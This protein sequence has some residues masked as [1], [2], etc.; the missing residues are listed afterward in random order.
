[1][2]S[3]PDSLFILSGDA[4]FNCLTFFGF[5]LIQTQTLSVFLNSDS[6]FLF[7]LYKPTRLSFLILAPSLNNSRGLYKNMASMIGKNVSALR[8][9]PP[10]NPPSTSSQANNSLALAA[11]QLP[12]YNIEIS[13]ATSLLYLLEI[14]DL[15]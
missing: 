5:T 11:L 2:R 3:R 9:A 6:V 13:C 15:M 1:M 4:P 8:A 14:K 12:P 7:H 10:I